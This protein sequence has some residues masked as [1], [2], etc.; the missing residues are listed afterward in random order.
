MNAAL[1][2]RRLFFALCNSRVFFCLLVNRLH[3]VCIVNPPLPQ[4]WCCRYT[5]AHI[6]NSKLLLH[7]VHAAACA[8]QV[9]KCP[10]AFSKVNFADSRLFFCETSIAVYSAPATFS[11]PAAR[12]REIPPLLLPL[13]PPPPLL[14]LPC[15]QISSMSPPPRPQT[16]HLGGLP[17]C[18]HGPILTGRYADTHSSRKSLALAL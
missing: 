3:A 7:G 13:P 15:D 5:D 1:L 14:A 12:A 2:V 11:N 6:H 17:I 16:F 10:D 18:L 4:T 9:Q 8:H